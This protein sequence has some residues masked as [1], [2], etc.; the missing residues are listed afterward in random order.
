MNN[1]SFFPKRINRGVCEISYY[2]ICANC[3]C[4]TIVFKTILNHHPSSMIFIDWNPKHLAIHF[5]KNRIVV[6]I[7][8]HLILLEPGCLG[9]GIKKLLY[10]FQT[11]NVSLYE[12]TTIKML[13]QIE[14]TKNQ[15]C[16][17]STQSNKHF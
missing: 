5:L 13:Y 4:I 10:L 6:F 9:E 3:R 17:R 1:F 15:G 16:V 12:L 7:M 14:K 2:L 11:N 8:Y